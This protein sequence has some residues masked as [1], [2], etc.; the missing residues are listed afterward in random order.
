LFVIVSLNNK[1]ASPQKFQNS[2]F[3]DFNIWVTIPKFCEID[4]FYT[5]EDIGKITLPKSSYNIDIFILQNLGMVTPT[6]KSL[7]REF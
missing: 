2:L 4:I 3:R 6:L 5:F 7:E 1:H